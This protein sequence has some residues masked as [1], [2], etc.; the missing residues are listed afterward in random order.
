[1]GNRLARFL[2]E[3]WGLKLAAL[4]LAVLLWLA[5]RAMDT[6]P[7]LNTF[8]NVPVRVDVRDP[9]WRLASDPD[10]PAVHVTVLGT[11]DELT[12]L[13]SQPPRITLT[14]ERV[15][16]SVETQVVPL[17]WVQLPRGLMQARVVAL[18]PDTIRL[19]Y[20][21]LAT[22]TVPVR[23]RIIGELPSGYR[24]ERPVNT[25]PPVVQLRGPARLVMQLDSVPLL[26][27]DISGLRSTTSVPASVDMAAIGPIR[28]SPEEINVVLR[29][30][31]VENGLDQAAD[32]LA[33]RWG[34]PF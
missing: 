34:G 9:D 30:V 12:A 8:P 18:R 26:P 3:R 5:V 4:A 14:V 29:I 1:M 11:R 10:P 7:V 33:W 23:I 16:D 13:L 22:R 32:T 27:V 25:N 21:R 20:E 17:Q 15:V 28:V 19:Q 24:L 6:T 2:S 31:P